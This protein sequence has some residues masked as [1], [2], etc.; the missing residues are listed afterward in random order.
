MFTKIYREALSYKSCLIIVKNINNLKVV[1][2]ENGEI[3]YGTFTQWK[4]SICSSMFIEMG[5]YI[6]NV[7]VSF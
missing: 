7:L 5:N 1:Q 4:K 3:N 2:L 6:H